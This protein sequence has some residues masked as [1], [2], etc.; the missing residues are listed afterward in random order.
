MTHQ[1]MIQVTL[2][3]GMLYLFLAKSSDNKYFFELLKDFT[4]LPRR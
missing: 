2:D 3:E 1:P 4:L